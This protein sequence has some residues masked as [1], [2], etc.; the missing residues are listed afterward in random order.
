MSTWSDED[1]ALREDANRRAGKLV[2]GK[3]DNK[4]DV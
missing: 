3:L 1:E 4:E 2:S